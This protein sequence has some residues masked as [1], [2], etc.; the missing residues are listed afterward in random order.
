MA[1]DRAE[2]VKVSGE[3]I[4]F[5]TRLMALPTAELLRHPDILDM[6]QLAVQFETNN[7]VD[8]KDAQFKARQA[9]RVGSL[10]VDPQ[11]RSIATRNPSIVPNHALFNDQFYWD[12]ERIV[13]GWLALNLSTKPDERERRLEVLKGAVQNFADIFNVIGRIPNRM[14][15]DF[16]NRS[17][18]PVFSKLIMDTYQEWDTLATTS[19]ERVRAKDWLVKQMAVAKEEYDTWTKSDEKDAV[20][21]YHHRVD[22]DSSLSR[23]GYTD[24]ADDTYSI[25]SETGHD[26]THEYGER[27]QDFQPVLLNTLLARYEMDFRD[28]ALLAGHTEEAADWEEKLQKRIAEMNQKMWNG[29]K[30]WFYN[31]DAQKGEQSTY[32]SL[33]G[34]MP[35]AMGLVT[36]E[37]AAKMV[38]DLAQFEMPYGLAMATEHEAQEAPYQWDRPNIWP[39]MVEFV[40]EGLEKYGYFAEEAKIR[41]SSLA[42]FGEFF[43]RHATTPERMNGVTGENGDHDHYD[44]Q[45][46]FGWTNAHIVKSMRWFAKY[47]E[48]AV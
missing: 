44:P 15:T 40:C 29:G 2:Q 12:T 26:K 31:Y 32:M 1:V 14:H 10:P 47:P 43:Q 4:P 5:P 45:E 21:K 23:W 37:Q 33:N 36:P 41:R 16:L 38:A 22:K 19:R 35:M 6:Y 3:I 30:G 18:P 39:N 13:D 8:N 9:F 11:T 34:F 28:T 42:A 24:V 27:P 20:I 48:Y 25:I 7:V 46:N 17:Q